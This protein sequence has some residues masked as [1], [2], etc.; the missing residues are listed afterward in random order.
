KP[1]GQGVRF[2]DGAGLAGEQEEGGL[3]GVLGLVGVAQQSPAHAQHQRAVPE[4]QGGKGGFLALGGET[5]EEGSI[6]SWVG[7]GHGAVLGFCGP[8]HHGDQGGLPPRRLVSF[9]SAQ[10]ASSGRKKRN[11]LAF[12]N[13]GR[14]GDVSLPVTPGERGMSVPR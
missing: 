13:S 1:A 5:P 4:D 2:A 8:G 7:A 6:R 14:A 11:R 9:Y 12:A 3:E 10:K